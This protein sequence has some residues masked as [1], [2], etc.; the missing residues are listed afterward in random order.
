MENSVN[1][2]LEIFLYSF[3]PLDKKVL[4][5]FH[6]KY[7]ILFGYNTD[8]VKIV[9]ILTSYY[10]VNLTFNIIKRNNTLTFLKNPSQTFIKFKMLL[11]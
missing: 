4:S 9:C 5:L 2:D 3:L 7:P 10:S 6:M 8:P 1:A 11:K